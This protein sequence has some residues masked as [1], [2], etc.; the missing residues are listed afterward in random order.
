M[1]EANTYRVILDRMLGRVSEDLDKREG[2]VLFDAHAP[3]A[4]EIGQLYIELERVLAESFGGTA[5]RQYLILRAAERGITPYPATHAILRAVA[6]PD[7]VDITGRRF[8]LGELNYIA[9]RRLSP[10]VFEMQ[11]ETAGAEGN[12]YFGRLSP[13][14]YVPGLARAELCEVLIPG[15]DE[16]ETEALRRRYFDSFDETAFG[17]NRRDYILKVNAIPGVGG[18][19]VQAV[20]NA[21]LNPA[22]LIPNTTV[23]AW[24][25]NTRGTLPAAPRAWLDAVYSAAADKKLTVGGTVRITLIDSEWNPP[26]PALV[27]AVQQAVDPTEYAGEGAGTAPIGHVV[28]VTGA[29][30]VP[31]DITTHMMFESGYSADVLRGALSETI[32]EYLLELRR[33]WADSERLVVRVSQIETRLLAVKG[34]LDIGGTAVNS[35]EKNLVLCEREI[36]VLGGIEDKGSEALREQQTFHGGGLCK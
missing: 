29:V 28:K 25:E 32:E 17:G 35:A 8:N 18:C 7:T 36:P 30:A 19:K 15:E 5:S 4:L 12:R 34:V 11:C 1:F 2:S 24:Y 21:D 23:R 31:I 33:A 9:V 10:G 16:E 3:A 6:E 27:D 14:E 20:W 26:T 22:Q 13:I